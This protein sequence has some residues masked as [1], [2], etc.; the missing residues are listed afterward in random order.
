MHLYGMYIYVAIVGPIWDPVLDPVFGHV[1]WCYIRY[2]EVVN[3]GTRR[4]YGYA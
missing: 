4:G 3:G 2:L 1:L